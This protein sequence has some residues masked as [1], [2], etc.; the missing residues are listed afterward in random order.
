MEVY[1]GD[2]LVEGEALEVVEHDCEFSEA[3]FLVVKGTRC[4]NYRFG[5]DFTA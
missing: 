4:P 2:V 3:A 1:E 5:C